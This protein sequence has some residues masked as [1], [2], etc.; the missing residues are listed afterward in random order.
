MFWSRTSYLGHEQQG[1][2]RGPRCRRRP[3]LLVR[4]GNDPAPPGD[5][6]RVGGSTVTQALDLSAQLL[7]RSDMLRARSE[8][9]RATASS[10]RATAR[11]KAGK[12]RRRPCRPP[13]AAGSV[14]G[15]ESGS[16]DSARLDSQRF[17]AV[18]VQSRALRQTS[19]ETRVRAQTTRDQARNGRSQRQILRD[20]AFAR[21]LAKMGTM[22]V[23]EQAKGI[24]IAQQGCGPDEAFDLLRLA[25]QRA[26]VKLRVLAAELVE[27]AASRGRGDGDK[28]TPIALGATKDLRPRTPDTATSRA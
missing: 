26:N 8:Q 10:R 12:R 23:I 18:R 1:I 22:S 17:E 19:A 6:R 16:G 9:A 3:V 11:E 25:S 28:V 5:A 13:Y 21:L 2:V 20:S 15:V 7:R 14:F 4:G 24:I 27:Q